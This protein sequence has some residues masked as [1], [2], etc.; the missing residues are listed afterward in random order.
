MRPLV[1]R[2][3]GAKFAFVMTLLIALISIV[4]FVYFPGRM[5]RQAMQAIHEKAQTVSQMTA[6]SISPAMVFDDV[7]SAATVLKGARQNPDLVY[8]V[9]IDDAGKRFAEHAIDAADAN[10]FLDTP[11]AG[12]LS[13]SGN[14]YK[15]VRPI[16]YEGKVIGRLYLG[17]SLGWVDEQIAASRAAVA[18]VSIILF[19]AGAVCVVIVS[20]YI[21]RPLSR[22]VETAE[23]IA[24]GDLSR[25]ARVTG[26]DEIGHLGEAFNVMVDRVGRAYE[27]LAQLNR[28]LESRVEARTHQLQV[29]IAERRDAEHALR[30]SEARYRLLFERN[31]AGVF[32]LQVDGMIVEC[33]DALARMLGFRHREELAGVHLDDLIATDEERTFFLPSLLRE[34][35]LTNTELRIRR[36]DGEI[37]W[38]L[39]NVSLLPQDRGA[40]PVIEGTIIDITGR[41]EA[42]WQVEYQAFHD[43]L[44]GLPNRMLFQDRLGT[45]LARARRHDES[46]AVMFLDLDRFKDVNDTFGHTA[47]DRLLESVADRLRACLREEDTVARLGGDEF[48]ILVTSLTG[49]TDVS[50]IAEQVLGALAQPIVIEGEELFVTGSIGI[51]MFPADGFDSETLLMRADRAMY[52]AKDAGRNNY[53]YWSGEVSAGA[54]DLAIESGL[55]RAI[56]NGELRLHYQPQVDILTWQIVAVEALLRWD[57][58]TRGLLLPGEFIPVAE[59]TRLIVPIGDWV[60]ETACRAARRWIDA[61]LP[62][63]RVAINLSA[64]QFQHADLVRTIEQVVAETGFDASRLEIE[65]T[66]TTAMLS[67]ER[68]LAQLQRLKEMKVQVSIDD[69]GTGHSS[70]AYLHRFPVDRI[71]IDQSF[72]RNIAT[73]RSAASLVAGMTAMAHSLGLK[74]IAE[75]VETQ[76]QLMVLRDSGCEEIQGHLF[77]IPLPEPDLRHLMM[78]GLQPARLSPGLHPAS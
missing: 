75:G 49:T 25:R 77:S 13:A 50:R 53:Q 14:V 43:A 73:D 41:K 52:Q 31:L 5:R 36:P 28:D 4:I 9:V 55:R 64:R 62:F 12:A 1:E 66:E 32:R 54:S 8:A 18:V 48:T 40:A 16:H 23:Q 76:E 27:D 57:H 56:L 21:T 67:S 15:V 42:E 22:I 26:D 69:F 24:A 59:E 2:S 60:L 34:R 19:L 35:G 58:A 78:H 68:T 37:G 61:G 3:I 74:V 38:I 7:E 6:F 10:H 17:M 11:A 39:A 33:N 29:E 70:L 71:K 20:S 63:G 47:G 72:V 44:T 65:V 51:A 46:L 30:D 45:A